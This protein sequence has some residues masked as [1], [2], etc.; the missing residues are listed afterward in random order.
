[1][2]LQRLKSQ[3]AI[4]VE[5]LHREFGVSEVTI[6]KDLNALD[7]R[8]LLIR[9]RGGAIGLPNTEAESKEDTPIHNKRFFNTR[10]KQAIGRVAATLIEENDTILL[11]SGTTTL[12]IARNLHK[13]QRLTIIT[14]SINIAAELL[15]YKRFNIILLGGNLRGASQSTVGPIAEM[16]LK[17]FYCDKLFLGVDSFNIECGLSTPNIEEANINQMMLSMSKRGI[18]VFDSSKCT[19]SSFAFIAPVDKIDVVVSDSNLPANIR[20]QLRSMQIKVYAAEVH[21]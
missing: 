9:T 16:N 13:F 8:N 11:D 17:V 18:A 19:K 5:E 14:N 2:I 1:M 3:S 12:E 10:E 15:G 4:S 6:R 21:P 20:N 7:E